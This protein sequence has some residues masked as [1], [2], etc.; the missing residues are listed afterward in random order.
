MVQESGRKLEVDVTGEITVRRPAHV[1]VR[2]D[3]D[4]ARK[5]LFY[6]GKLLTLLLERENAYS[7]EEVP[8]AIDDMLAFVRDK[9]G[10][11]LP[12]M[13]LLYSDVWS[14]LQKRVDFGFYVGENSV[15]G[16]PCHH[17][18]LSNESVDAQIWVQSAGPPVPRRMVLAFRAL[19]GAPKRTARITN[20]DQ[21]ARHEDAYF[22]FSP[23]QGA[24]KITFVPQLPFPVAGEGR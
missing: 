20:W 22:A 7:Q 17:L 5:Q 9:M 15:D 11:N 1:R 12:L 13:D 23:P 4:G 18:A 6:D 2:L 8:G 10:T 3:R 24:E 14:L 16:V 19:P 21:V